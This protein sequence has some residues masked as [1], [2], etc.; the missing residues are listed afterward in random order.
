MAHLETADG[1]LEVDRKTFVVKGNKLQVQEPSVKQM[2][3]MGGKE[4][5]DQEN[6][7]AVGGLRNPYKAIKHSASTWKL[8]ASMRHALL[9]VLRQC[10]EELKS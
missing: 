5:R 9:G 6:E 3:P 4:L 1:K 8:G 7:A 10:P 2:A